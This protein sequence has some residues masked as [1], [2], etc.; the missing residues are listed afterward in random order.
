M[1]PVVVLTGFLG[2]GKTTLINRLL[3]RG[4]MG[5]VGVIVNELGSVGIDGAL[6]GGAGGGARQVELPGGCVC[7]QI[8]DE[9]EQTVVDL[10]DS[11][12]ELRALLLE[13]TGVAEPIPI[14]WAL[15]KPPASDRVRVAAVVTVVDA[16]NFAASRAVS[17]AVDAQIAYA[18]VLLVTKA[19]L[20]AASR[21]AVRALAPRAEIRDGSTDDHA[22]W[23]EQ[24]VAD[25]SLPRVGDPEPTHDHE[26]DHHLVGSVS[27]DIAG[28]VDLEE[29]EDQLAALPAAYVRIKGIARAI[30]GRRGDAAPRWVAIHRVGLRVSSEPV[31]APAGWTSGKIVAL[32]NGVDARQ[33]AACVSASEVS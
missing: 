24:L 20:D 4:R 33:L 25:P 30:D 23:L 2:A 5:R 11:T 21:A 32:G 28:A 12:P 15:D 16:D 26:H 8:G 9:L 14:A 19:P 27:V 6:L 22:A 1:V 13:T 18:D 7:C 31:D 3:A 29:L 10:V 17:T